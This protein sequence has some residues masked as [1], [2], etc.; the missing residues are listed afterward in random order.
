MT[1]KVIDKICRD[2]AE[3]YGLPFKEV[4][5]V[6]NSEFEFIGKHINLIKF[7]DI[8]DEDEFDEAKAQTG[9]FLPELF[10]LVPNK[11]RWRHILNSKKRKQEILKQ[12]ANERK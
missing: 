2:I 11:N 8:Y 9:F 6:Y 3:E 4:E 10:R 7:K 5:R 12:K 1:D